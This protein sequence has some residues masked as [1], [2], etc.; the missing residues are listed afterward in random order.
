MSLKNATV[1]VNDQG[2]FLDFA[3]KGWTTSDGHFF[4]GTWAN[5]VRVARRLR[6]EPGGRVFVVTDYGFESERRQEVA[7]DGDVGEPAFPN[8]P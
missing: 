4:H 7:E 6:R 8:R 1:I 2:Q 3:L 5:A